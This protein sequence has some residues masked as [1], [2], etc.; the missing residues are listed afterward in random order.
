MQQHNTISKIV[1]V[2]IGLVIG[3]AIWGRVEVASPQTHVMPDGTIMNND[4]S[5]MESM[6]H[7][8]NAA[9]VG[10]EG[11]VFDQTFLSEMIV[12]HQGAIDMANL[13][14]VHAKHQEIKDLAR[15]IIKAQTTEITQ[16]K[17]WQQKWF[18][19]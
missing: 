4:G 13:A 3:W 6:M 12:H 16:M 11:D 2:V 5:S 18:N 19:K 1:F 8:M 14:L 10:K 9:L 15:A 7:D 17:E